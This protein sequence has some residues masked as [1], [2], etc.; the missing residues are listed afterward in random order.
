MS[1]SSKINLFILPVLLGSSLLLSACNK[2]KENPPEQATTQQAQDELQTAP[3]KAYPAT[4]NDAHDIALLDD[5]DE[6]FTAMS[7]DMENELAQMQQAGNLTPEFER[8][9]KLD[10]IQSALNMLKELDLKT[11]QGRYIQGMLYQYWES[12]GQLI[13]QH[14]ASGTSQDR[15]QAIT[16]KNL[17]EYLQAQK[18]LKHWKQQQKAS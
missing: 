12:Q 4:E 18:Q 8:N 14:T 1:N 9:R 15:A 11:A 17:A 3:V 13:Q 10:H 5:F 6:K 16:A 2:N 7:D